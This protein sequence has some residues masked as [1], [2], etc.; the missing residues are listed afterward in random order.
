MV[1]TARYR[2]DIGKLFAVEP[3]LCRNLPQEI[4]FIVYRVTLYIGETHKP[5]GVSIGGST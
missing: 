5:L 1:W 2:N 3:R 4:L